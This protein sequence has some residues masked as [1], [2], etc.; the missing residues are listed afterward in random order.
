MNLAMTGKAMIAKVLTEKMN[1]NLE[2]VIC[3]ACRQ[4]QRDFA[5]KLF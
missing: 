3:F 5:Y 1:G 4:K 2:K